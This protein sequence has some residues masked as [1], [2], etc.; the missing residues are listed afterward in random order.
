MPPT[1]RSHRC[2][3]GRRFGRVFAGGNDVI[4]P[5]FFSHPLVNPLS[6]PTGAAAREPDPLPSMDNNPD[7]PRQPTGLGPFRH[8]RHL[9]V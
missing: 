1:L 8:T 2:H 7:T 6:L 3:S 9:G 5:S 4:V